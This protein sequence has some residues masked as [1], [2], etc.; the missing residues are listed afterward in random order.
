MYQVLPSLLFSKHHLNLA[1]VDVIVPKGDAQ[2]I[3]PVEPPRQPGKVH[4]RHHH[5]GA[6]V[7]HCDL[8][9]VG[10][11]LGSVTFDSMEI[12][13]EHRPGT[14]HVLLE[15]CAPS[16]RTRLKSNC[17]GTGV[18]GQKLNER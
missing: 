17:Y 10:T 11:T 15:A 14:V 9:K 1:P 13:I 16:L 4:F 6:S 12:V 2:G 3:D 7:Q 8:S 5:Y 18:Q